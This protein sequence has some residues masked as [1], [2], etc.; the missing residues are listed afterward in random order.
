MK[1]RIKYAAL[2]FLLSA[3]PLLNTESDPEWQ[4][5]NGDGFYPMRSVACV[6][7]DTEYNI[8]VTDMIEYGDYVYAGTWGTRGA[9]IYRQP[10][11]YGDWENTNINLEGEGF[12][13]TSFGI[14]TGGWEFTPPGLY[15]GTWDN[16]GFDIFYLENDEWQ[17]VTTKGFEMPSMRAATSLIEYQGKLFVGVF[18]SSDEGGTK[19]GYIWRDE[20]GEWHFTQVNEDGF[21]DSKNTDSTSMT[22]VSHQGKEYLC[23]G[24]EN[25]EQGGQGTEVWCGCPGDGR[26]TWRQIN[27]DGFDYVEGSDKNGN[28]ALFFASDG[29]LY[30][31]TLNLDTGCEVWRYTGDYQTWYDSSHWERILD[32]GFQGVSPADLGV[33]YSIGFRAIA[34]HDGK[35]YFGTGKDNLQ[36]LLNANLSSQEIF[37][38][39]LEFIRE[40][41][42]EGAEL[43][44]YQNGAWTL[45][46]G[47][48]VTDPKNYR[49]NVL[50][51]IGDRLRIGA[52]RRFRFDVYMISN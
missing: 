52:L 44:S 37:V 51:E 36:S 8:G 43:W 26:S 27:A 17:E 28:V 16:D 1:M 9:R 4:V 15:V 39:L 45:E 46:M 30:A 24:T 14:Y 6:M 40:G 49:I 29:S 12:T 22:K 5:L 3:F 48:G 20:Y 50:R 11:P 23:V 25:W 42:A 31:G 38:S 47:D 32:R 7:V 41:T 35:V 19:V 18:R 10:L 21:G 13:V 33:N 34:E 2:I